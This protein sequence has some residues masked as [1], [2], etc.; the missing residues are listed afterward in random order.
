MQ[1]AGNAAFLLVAAGKRAHLG[2]RARRLD[3]HLP[4]EAG[5]DLVLAPAADQ[6]A[7]VVD[8]ELGNRDVEGDR[9]V[10][11]QPLGLAILRQQADAVREP[12]ARTVDRDRLCR[13]S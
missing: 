1:L 9:L 5:D 13:R 6:T 8:G 10:E 3:A 12:L 4:D 2:A 11:E 7:A